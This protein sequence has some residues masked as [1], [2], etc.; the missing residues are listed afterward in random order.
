LGI[1]QPAKL[2]RIAR[3]RSRFRMRLSVIPGYLEQ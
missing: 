2:I 1:L 3:S